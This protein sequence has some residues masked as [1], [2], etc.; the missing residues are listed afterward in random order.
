MV[1][2]APAAS[3]AVNTT[4]SSSSSSSSRSSSSSSSSWSGEDA[5]V[6]FSPESGP[7]GAAL[8]AS[9]FSTSGSSPEASFGSSDEGGLGAMKPTEADTA[10]MTAGRTRQKQIATAP[11]L[12]DQNE[13]GK[14]NGTTPI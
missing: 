8:A 14:A 5:A 4:R 7:A 2:S 1:A 10:G 11:I 3:F 9:F 6:A 12:S 13:F